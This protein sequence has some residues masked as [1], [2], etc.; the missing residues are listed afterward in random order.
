LPT[1]S[2]NQ[3]VDLSS[4]FVPKFFDQVDN[5]LAQRI[6]TVVEQFANF[7]AQIND[8]LEFGIENTLGDF[9]F[10]IGEALGKGG[11]VI[12]AGGAA[13]LGGIASILNQLGQA[14]I[15]IGIG[16][17][18]IKEAFKNPFTAIAAGV[19]LIA[20]A[21]FI[22][23]KVPK[24]TSPIGQGGGGSFS[25]SG[26]QGVGGGQASNFSGGSTAGV[27]DPNRNI[28]LSGGFE[29]SGDKL[30]YVLNQSEGFRN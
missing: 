29:I 8:T 15:G 1:L 4:E 7:A 27:F 24:I 26:G 18:A 25:G 3:G 20:L 13:L 12:E 19:G 16:M 22:S 9:A 28:T 10:S 21:G 23:S 17:I 5:I 11:N 2:S 6:P 30:R 14:A